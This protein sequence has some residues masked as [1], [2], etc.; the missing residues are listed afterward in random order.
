MGCGVVEVIALVLRVVGRTL[1]VELGAGT[2]LVVGGVS[3]TRF[4]A[5]SLSKSAF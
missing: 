4:A 3:W 1:T 5:T 2:L